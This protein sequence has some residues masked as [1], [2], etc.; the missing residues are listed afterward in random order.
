MINILLKQITVYFGLIILMGLVQNP[1]IYGWRGTYI[2]VRIPYK[3]RVMTT[4]GVIT[5]SK[6]FIFSATNLW[7]KPIHYEK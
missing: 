1:T 3:T 5:T 7:S 2:S 4:N 6:M